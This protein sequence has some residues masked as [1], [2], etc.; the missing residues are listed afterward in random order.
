MNPDGSLSPGVMNFAITPAMKPMMIVQMMCIRDPQSK[1]DP[2]VAWKRTCSLISLAHD[3]T[4]WADASG[5]VYSGGAPN[6]TG[7]SN[8]SGSRNGN[9]PAHNR[10]PVAADASGPQHPSTA[11]DS[12][13]G[14]AQ[15]ERTECEHGGQRG[16]S[17]PW[18]PPNLSRA[19]Q[20][21]MARVNAWAAYGLF[22]QHRCK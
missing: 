7:A 21:Q 22:T 19:R 8:N 4:V 9:G 17:H 11:N 5:P 14:W 20:V 13:S 15:S 12:V 16:A 18:K 6:S 10:S 3:G 2:G 1:T